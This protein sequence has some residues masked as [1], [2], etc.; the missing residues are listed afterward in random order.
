MASRHPEVAQ[1]PESRC[2]WL[3]F[4]KTLDFDEFP[5]FKVYVIKNI[6]L[7]IL[8]EKVSTSFPTGQNPV[9]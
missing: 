9:T 8:I 6:Y 5:N 7:F 1:R 4:T 3:P 2:T